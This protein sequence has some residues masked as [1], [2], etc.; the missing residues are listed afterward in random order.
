M[1]K[2]KINNNLISKIKVTLEKITK[3][4]AQKIV[5]TFDK[6]RTLYIDKN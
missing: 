3:E 1:D 2:N 4:M 6:I 5:T